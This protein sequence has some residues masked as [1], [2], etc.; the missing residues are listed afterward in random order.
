MKTLFQTL[1]NHI[2]LVNLVEVTGAR[3]CQEASPD[4]RL[5]VY[6]IMFGDGMFVAATA[7]HSFV[8]MRQTITT[9]SM[10]LH[11]TADKVRRGDKIWI[12]AGAI[13]ADGSLSTKQGE[14]VKRKLSE[15]TA[16]G[17]IDNIRLYSRPLEEHKV[18]LIGS[19]V[20]SLLENQWPSFWK[21]PQDT[22]KE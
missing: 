5:A 13:L 14:P 11:L 16:Q 21:E 12:S 20:I 9:E 6:Q 15:K 10:E 4:G 17:I 1:I 22:D 7:L 18:Q 19:Y 2:G 8:A 3:L